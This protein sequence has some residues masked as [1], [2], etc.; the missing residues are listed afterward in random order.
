MTD[1]F[2]EL[3]GHSLLV[4]RLISQIDRALGTRLPVSALF[5]G[6]TI[7]KLAGLLRNRADGEVWSP[8]VPLQP[9]G[10]KPPFFCV[11]PVG[12]NVVCYAD[13]SRKLGND[14]P[15]YA[16]QAHGLDAHPC[17]QTIEEMAA[18]YISSLLIIQ[19]Q[20][21]YFLGGWSLGGLVAFEMGRQLTNMREEV[22]LIALFDCKAPDHDE[23][24]N[25]GVDQSWLSLGFARDLGLSV[26]DGEYSL[27]TLYELGIEEQLTYLLECAKRAKAIPPDLDVTQVS[28]LFEVFKT[29][30]MASRR[31]S[32]PSSHLR[33]VLFNAEESLTKA[34]G[35]PTRG[36]SALAE[37]GVETHTISGHHYSILNEPHLSELTKILRSYF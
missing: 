1:N 19:P 33:V 14:H 27:D 16:F 11:H 2:F 30:L 32:P 15:F 13:L 31:Y 34:S 20:G 37:G 7:E 18:D 9:T 6:G 12:G 28:I 25:N 26:S 5:S 8:L 10:S 24:D 21:P 17:I 4:V 22:G 29:N 3:G 35:D 23:D 36:W